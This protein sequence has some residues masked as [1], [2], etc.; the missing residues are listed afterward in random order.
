MQVMRALLP[1]LQ[2]AVH[3]KA[4]DAQYTVSG[5]LTWRQFHRLAGRGKSPARSK[6][7]LGSFLMA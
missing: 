5:P 3:A 6:N 2:E 1:L 4:W 7:V